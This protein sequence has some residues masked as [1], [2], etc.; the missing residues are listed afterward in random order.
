MNKLLISLNN[1]NGV[2]DHTIPVSIFGPLPSIGSYIVIQIKDL[3]KHNSEFLKLE[4]N[5]SGLPDN[6]TEYYKGYEPD[7]SLSN[8]SY[9]VNFSIAS[10]DKFHQINSKPLNL[11]NQDKSGF[12]LPVSTFQF[13]LHNILLLTPELQINGNLKNE[14]DS[15][16]KMTL[17]SPEVAFGHSV[18]SKLYAEAAIKSS[19][20]GWSIFRQKISLPNTPIVPI[21]DEVIIYS[22]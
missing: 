19:R 3:F 7:Y 9:L 1:S 10:S 18:F 5:W 15:K 11:F 8:L 6:L 13:E 21:A 17:I 20:F 16:L 2:L 4:I 14:S 12:I 22:I